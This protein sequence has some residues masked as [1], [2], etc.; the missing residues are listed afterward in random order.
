MKSHR[1]LLFVPGHKEMFYDSALHYRPDAII[2]DLEDSVPDHLFETAVAT[3]NK[4]S[5]IF[6][7]T[8]FGLYLRVN[9]KFKSNAIENLNRILISNFSGIFLPKVENA[10]QV[11][12]LSS[13]LSE[14]EKQTNVKEFSISIVLIIETPKGFL[15][16][17]EIIE[18]TSRITGLAFGGEDYISSI[19][20]KR[21]SKVM[22]FAR[23]Q[24]LLHAKAHNLYCFDTV[25]P[26]T[27]N[28]YKHLKDE[29]KAAKNMGFD[30]KMIIHPSHINEVHEVFKYDLSEIR[31]YEK[32]VDIFDNNNSGVIQV[33]NQ[34]YE[35]P[36]IERYRKIIKDYYK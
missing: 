23:N 1:S 31:N 22:D 29:V 14:Y 35:K 18:S 13:Y 9:N 11:I 27:S 24:I 12:E 32:I 3:I 7:K 17:P 16:L 34:I 5:D 6:N 4:K 20:A 28:N 26:N 25:F 33:D 15:N 10:S 2:L 36:H 30:G 19:G 8:D 21:T